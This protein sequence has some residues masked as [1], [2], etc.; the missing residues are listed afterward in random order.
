MIDTNEGGFMRNAIIVLLLVCSMSALAQQGRLI[1][2]PVRNIPRWIRTEFSNRNLDERYIIIFE[3]FPYTL[4]GDFNGDG[5][6]DVAI[7]VQDKRTGKNGIAIFHGK[8]TQVISTAI[9]ILGAGNDLGKAG[10]NFQWVNIWGILKHRD[11]AQQFGKNRPAEIEGDIITIAKR[12]SMNGMI[13][14]DGRKYNYFQ[15]NTNRP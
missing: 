13:Y 1:T 15:D 5:K 9:T 12:D 3:L 6:R 11:L 2:N 4:Q 7:Q 14:W 8:K 10:T